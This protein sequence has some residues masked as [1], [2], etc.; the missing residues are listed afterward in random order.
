MLTK[1]DVRKM[2]DDLGSW[3]KVGKALDLPSRTAWKYATDPTYEPRRQDIRWKLGMDDS[4]VTYV[5]QV[6]Q[7]NGTFTKR[8]KQ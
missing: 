4:P 1:A 7:S 6:R 3:H 8:D 2:K 5:R